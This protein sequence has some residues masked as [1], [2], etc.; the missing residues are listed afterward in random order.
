MSLVIRGA[1]LVREGRLEKKDLAVAGGMIEKVLSPG[2]PYP[3]KVLRGDGLFLSH[4]FIDIHVHG[5]GGSDF[6]DGT[7][8]AWDRIRRLH[9]THGTTGMLATTL[10]A[11]LE[12]MQAVVN[13]FQRCKGNLGD[14]ARLLGLHM[15]GPYLSPEQSGA[16]D[17]VYIRDPVPEEYQ[18]LIN[19]CPGILRWTV[20]PEL[21]GAL[22]M[23]DYLKT[24]GVLSSIGHSN[25]TYSQ[26][27][28][29]VAHGFT[30]VTHLYSAMSSITRVGGFRRGGV[31]ESAYVLPGLTSE[32]I[33]DGCHLP[34]ELLQMAYHFIGP[35]RLAL[36]TDAM[37]AAGQETGES[38]L[39]SLQC[40]VPVVIE[41]GVAKMPDKKAFAGSICTG[42]RLV[43][44]MIRLAGAT[45]AD[46]VKM[47]TETP[48]RIM[49][50]ADTW[51]I[52]REGRPADLVLF[53]ENIQVKSV[54]TDGQVRY[55][56]M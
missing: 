15:E 8:E 20:A 4:G 53:D 24:K 48:A 31:V 49:G 27:Q 1:T 51:G 17:P 39:G 23:G 41:D 52:V 2:E 44:T 29:A 16:Q 21:S 47:A 40:G 13:L 3:G 34:A 18:A 50:L 25:A 14:G 22:R 33:A 55:S 56:C 43:R 35:D 9:L 10:A 36:V 11:S 28:K 42:D 12:E 26:V 32:V 19:S 30:H 38:I 6:M 46:A 37:R 5:G 45:L 54:M 7:P